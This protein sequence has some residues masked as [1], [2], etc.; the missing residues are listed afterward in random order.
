MLVICRRLAGFDLSRPI[1]HTPENHFIPL[2]IRLAGVV[3][4][5]PD[6]FGDRS[7]E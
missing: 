4:I 3:K 5:A 7:V 6:G 1:V 2:S